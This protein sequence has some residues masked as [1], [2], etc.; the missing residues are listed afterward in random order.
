MTDKFQVVGDFEDYIGAIA[1]NSDF[2]LRSPAGNFTWLP[3]V[4][5]AIQERLYPPMAPMPIDLPTNPTYGVEMARWND[6]LSQR[7]YCWAV[8]H[9]LDY[10]PCPGAGAAPTTD[11]A[12]SF[13][14]YFVTLRRGQP[15]HR[16]ARQ[17]PGSPGALLVPDFVDDT[18]PAALLGTSVAP[19]ALPVT[20]DVMFPVPWR[21]QI[22]IV[23]PLASVGIPA[24]AITNSAAYPTNSLVTD[25]IQRG[26]A[27]IDELSGKVY[28]VT[29]REVDPSAPTPRAI[30][31]LDQEITLAEWTQYGALRTVWV[32]PP[33]AERDPSGAVIG[34]TGPQPVVGVEVRRMTF[35][36]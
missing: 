5:V 23:A 4:Q 3:N 33:P 9:K 17:D 8:F 6:L 11:S 27:L 22:E 19:A 31:T 24:Q 7:R 32:F 25:M 10:D 35:W 12:R 14:V 26:S 13:T 18:C 36:P 15:T 34:F 21:V 20:E 2:E 30:V 1:P 29:S 28:E 16:Y